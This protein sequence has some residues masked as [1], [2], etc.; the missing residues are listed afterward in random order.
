MRIAYSLMMLLPLF[1]GMGCEKNTSERV[2]GPQVCRNELV[3]T[4]PNYNSDSF[5][6]FVPTA[7]TPDGYGESLNN[8][9]YFVAIGYNS[10]DWFILDTHGKVVFASNDPF[11]GWDGT[12][13]GVKEQGE[14]EFFAKVRTIHDET[15]YVNQR[16]VIIDVLRPVENCKECRFRDQI[17]RYRGYILPTRENIKCK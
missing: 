11:E 4:P 3:I 16:I 2:I 12:V 9:F 13:N 14:Y 15:I 5:A 17:E 10:I 7:F 6:I 8:L 1:V